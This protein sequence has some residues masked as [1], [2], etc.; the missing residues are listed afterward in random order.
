MHITNISVAV[1]PR[2]QQVIIQIEESDEQDIMYQ[3]FKKIIIAQYFINSP[4][5][6]SG[7]NK[8]GKTRKRLQPIT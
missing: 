8:K 2:N 4:L 6:A 5:S 3:V 7:E 1:K